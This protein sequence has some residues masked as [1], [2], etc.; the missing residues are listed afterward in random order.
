MLIKSP[1]YAVDSAGKEMIFS[2]ILRRIDKNLPVD[3]ILRIY[4][5]LLQSEEFFRS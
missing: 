5:L 3:K 4:Q 2:R 1:G